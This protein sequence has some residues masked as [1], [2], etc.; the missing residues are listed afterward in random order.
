MEIYWYCI[1]IFGAGFG[2]WIF[3]YCCY[4][5]DKQIAKRKKRTSNSK[6][7]RR[8]ILSNKYPSIPKYSIYQ[9]LQI[10][11]LFSITVNFV[12]Q[13]SL[14]CTEKSENSKFII[15]Q[16]IKFQFYSFYMF[17]ILSFTHSLEKRSMMM[18]NYTTKG[19]T[20]YSTYQILCHLRHNNV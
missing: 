10:L 7:P 2:I 14:P 4:C 11:L 5:I 12:L 9:L 16:K 19:C 18:M 20:Y 3:C 6:K 17:A 8:I 15:L 1:I 13:K